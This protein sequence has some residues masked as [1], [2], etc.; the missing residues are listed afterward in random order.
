MVILYVFAFKTDDPF[1]SYVDSAVNE[2]VPF[3]ITVISP[4]FESAY[5][6]VDISVSRVGVPKSVIFY[7]FI[8]TEAIGTAIVSKVV[9]D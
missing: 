7:E 4:N 2:V 5:A 1:N 9:L 8:E 3:Y 6:F